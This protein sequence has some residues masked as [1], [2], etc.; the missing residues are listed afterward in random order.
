MFLH[1]WKKSYCRVIMC[2]GIEVVPCK[3]W[4]NIIIHYCKQHGVD[5]ERDQGEGIFQLV[6]SFVFSSC[7]G[8]W[9]PAAD[10]AGYTPLSLSLQILR[11]SSAAK[12][13]PRS[14]AV[15]SC[16]LIC[17]PTSS[18]RKIQIIR[19]WNSFTLCELIIELVLS[20]NLNRYIQPWAGKKILQ[21][22]E[23]NHTNKPVLKSC[24]RQGKSCTTQSLLR[25]YHSTFALIRI[26]V[27]YWWMRGKIP[28]IPKIGRQS[29]GQFSQEKGSL[30]KPVLN[31]IPP[32]GSCP[33]PWLCWWHSYTRD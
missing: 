13:I 11:S 29:Y 23:V 8:S 33:L 32:W 19:Q 5:L 18:H 16:S 21:A 24:I 6:C 7:W 20:I 31:F 27:C 1:H 25:N 3:S 4:F 17:N 26:K 10:S 9:I 28:L 15:L 12:D 22:Y 14:I 2:C 30:F